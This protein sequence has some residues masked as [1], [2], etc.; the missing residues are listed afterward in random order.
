MD[1]STSDF[2]TKISELG[3]AMTQERNSY[4]AENDAWWGRLSIKEREDAFYAVVKRIHQGE[5]VDQGSYRYI[6]YD[7][8]DFDPSMYIRGM[9]CGFLALHNAIKTDAEEQIIHEYY[10]SRNKALA[11]AK[12]AVV[13]KHKDASGNCPLHN[14]HCTYPECEKK[15]EEV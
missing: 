3:E 7:I 15:G 9:D 8:F 6:L 4:E 2:L 1:M 14:L 10:E 5:L 12:Q 11:A 13:C